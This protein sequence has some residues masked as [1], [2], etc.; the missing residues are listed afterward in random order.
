MRKSS[1]YDCVDLTKSLFTGLDTIPESFPPEIRVLTSLQNLLIVANVIGENVPDVIGLLPN[2]RTFTIE[3]NNN[4]NTNNGASTTQI[5]YQSPSS[6]SAAAEQMLRLCYNCCCKG[7]VI[8]AAA[9]VVIAL[10]N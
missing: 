8:A 5:I 9:V 1:L 7:M 4:G 10:L 6:S 2:L 3:Q